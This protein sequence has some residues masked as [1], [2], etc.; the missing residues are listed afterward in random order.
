M[1]QAATTEDAIAALFGD[2]AAREMIA[3]HG[4]D[5]ARKIARRAI[6]KDTDPIIARV[7]NAGPR[8]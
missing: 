5:G 1:A 6:S 4:L 2:L 3:R 8:R 7:L